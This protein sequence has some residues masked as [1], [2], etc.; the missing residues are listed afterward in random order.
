MLDRGVN[1]GRRITRGPERP[2]KMT[3]INW[4]TVVRVL[5]EQGTANLEHDSTASRVLISLAAALV[6]GIRE[7]R[8]RSLDH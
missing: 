4:A 2:P 3:D 1:A 7:A 6:E 8:W 5:R